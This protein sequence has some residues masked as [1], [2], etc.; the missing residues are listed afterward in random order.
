MFRFISLISLISLLLGMTMSLSAQNPFGSFDPKK[1][2]AY[3]DPMGSEKIV[4]DE[5]VESKVKLPLSDKESYID[6]FVNVY[7]NGDSIQTT[8]VPS[9]HF[10]AKE[11]RFFSIIADTVKNKVFLSLPRLMGAFPL[12]WEDEQKF[13]F[14]HP[15]KRDES[16]PLAILYSDKN[17]KL[18]KELR[19]AGLIDDKNQTETP[20]KVADFLKTFATITFKER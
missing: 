18:E 19:K 15:D 13:I 9:L 1:V 16:I 12:K 5:A 4:S 7:E 6:L 10:K 11:S 3:S 20:Q 14:T 17:D 2:R 8:P